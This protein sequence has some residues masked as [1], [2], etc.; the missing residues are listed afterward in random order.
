[1]G[2][3]RKRITR[4]VKE[5]VSLGWSSV[6]LFHRDSKRPKYCIELSAQPV[7]LV[8]VHK[9]LVVGSTQQSL[10]GFTYKVWS[11][12]GLSPSTS[13]CPDPLAENPSEYLTIPAP[14]LF[15]E[16]PESPADTSFSLPG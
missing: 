1:V 3:R 2:L 5:K 6:S 10:Q 11:P 4:A 16:S 9:I 7:G 14:L 12:A 13:V 15:T 8:R